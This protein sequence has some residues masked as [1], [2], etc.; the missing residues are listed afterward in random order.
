MILSAYLKNDICIVALKWIRPI[1]K[2]TQIASF[3]HVEHLN[4]LVENGRFWF[5]LE[6]N[7]DAEWGTLG[8][9]CIMQLFP[10]FK[11][12]FMITSTM[13]TPSSGLGGITESCTYRP[14][15]RCR[16]RKSKHLV[17]TVRA[18]HVGMPFHMH[19]TTSSFE[20]NIF[21]LGLGWCRCVV[22]I[23]L[24]EMSVNDCARWSGIY[25]C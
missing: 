15:R 12:G 7:H 14:T 9:A 20:P 6:N 18:S 4:H 8:H 21:E 10:M 19:L 23:Q 11:L 13:S 16:P 24:V 3:C 25:F 5:D 17:R 1:Y 2:M 22:K